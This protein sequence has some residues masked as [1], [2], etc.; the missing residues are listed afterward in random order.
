[1]TAWAIIAATAGLFAFGAV[2]YRAGRKS[3]QN[4]ALLARD[5]ENDKVDQLIRAHAHLTRDELLGRLRD[6]KDK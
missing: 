6:G 2:M 3:A 1:M 4:E 5:K